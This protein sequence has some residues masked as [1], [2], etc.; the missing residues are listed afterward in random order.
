MGGNYRGGSLITC[1]SLQ[2]VNE[3]WGVCFCC[4]VVFK[5]RAC[6]NIVL[7]ELS[8]K[9][10]EINFK[11]KIP[12]QNTLTD[13]SYSTRLP[14]LTWWWVCNAPTQTR[15]DFTAFLE[16]SKFITKHGRLTTTTHLEL[17][18]RRLMKAKEKSVSCSTH[19]IKQDGGCP[20]PRQPEDQNAGSKL[21]QK[22]EN[23][24]HGFYECVHLKQDLNNSRVLSKQTTKNNKTKQTNTKNKTRINGSLQNLRQQ[25]VPRTSS[26]QRHIADP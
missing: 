26:P 11:M 25:K 22:V 4:L 20:E 5:C 2:V 12:F 10:I 8:G 7:Y 18:V 16:Q 24:P 6:G 3:C 13:N 17:R 21:P 23:D 9:Y 15:G 14:T 19:E 1:R